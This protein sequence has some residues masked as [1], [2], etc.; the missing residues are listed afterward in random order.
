MDDDSLIGL[1]SDRMRSSICDI[2][3]CTQYHNQRHLS[4]VYALAFCLRHCI[5]IHRVRQAE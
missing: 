3:W 5:Y 2:Y 1:V 4:V